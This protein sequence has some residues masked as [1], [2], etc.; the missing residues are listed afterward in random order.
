MLP[1]Q[2]PGVALSTCS[3]NSANT[4]KAHSFQH[5]NLQYPNLW[6]KLWKMCGHVSP[7]PEY[8]D[9]K[10]LQSYCCGYVYWCLTVNM[11]VWS[12]WNANTRAT[13]Q[14]INDAIVSG[15]TLQYYEIEI[16]FQ[17]F[18]T[19]KC[20]LNVNP[21]LFIINVQFSMVQRLVLVE[22]I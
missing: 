13:T 14:Q 15:C 22:N 11:W 20:L 21:G 19:S 9:C 8:K 5:I 3:C 2:L 10:I 1:Y 17:Q 12:S 18:D 16:F 6:N 4:I 7:S